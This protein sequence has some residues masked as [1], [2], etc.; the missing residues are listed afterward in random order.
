M[1][2][3]S[4]VFEQVLTTFE[5]VL[6]HLVH[7]FPHDPAAPPTPPERWGVDVARAQDMLLLHFSF[8]N[9]I[10]VDDPDGP[11]LMR[12]T[13]DEDAYVVVRFPPQSLIEK[14]FDEN[15]AAPAPPGPEPI[16]VPTTAR[17]AQP[18]RLAFRV[19][20]HV[21]RIPLTLEALLDWES[22]SPHLAPAALPRGAAP[23]PAPP[24]RPLAGHE[25]AIELPYR[26]LL[27]PDETAVWRHATKPVEHSGRVELWHT[28]L[29][30][31][32]DAPETGDAGSVRAVW[33]PDVRVVPT[34][35][36]PRDMTFPMDADDR[37]GIVHQSA[38]FALGS[39]PATDTAPITAEQ[40]MLSATGGW[41][42]SVGMWRGTS[43]ISLSEWRHR[44][45]EGRDH[46]V[47]IVRE[48]ILF[49]FGHRAAVVKISERKVEGLKADGSDPVAA[50]RRRFYII[51]RQLERTYASGDYD[52]GGREFPLPVVRFVT[53]VTPNIDT[54]THEPNTTGTFWVR[55]AGA[56]Y[57]FALDGDDH[58]GHTVPF[59]AACL[60]V[61]LQDMPTPLP[62]VPRGA[63]GVAIPQLVFD[64]T[65]DQSL[66]AAIYADPA[67]A[68]AR[69]ADVEGRR[70]AFVPGSGA[71]AG[72]QGELA[73]DT[74]VLTAQVGPVKHRPGGATGR[75]SWPGVVPALA[76][77]T[78][79]I[80][81]L[82]T[83]AQSPATTV[84]YHDHYLDHAFD[85]VANHLEVF[86]RTVG[87]KLPFDFPADRASG[88]VT[89]S[90]SVDGLSRLRGPLGDVDK[91]VSGTF[92]PTSFFG[93]A[94]L[95]GG[96]SLSDLIDAAGGPDPV[97]MPR[98]VTE[99]EGLRM[100]TRIDWTPKVTDHGV[101]AWLAPPAGKAS[102]ELHAELAAGPGAAPGATVSAT[103]RALRL[104][105]P[106][107][108]PWITVTFD[109]L[110]CEL[111]PGQKPQI[112][113]ALRTP[114]LE[115]GGPL[116]FVGEL[117]KILPADGLSAGPSIDLTATGLGVGY[118][119]AIPPLAVGVF[120]LQDLRL[121][122]SL[123]LPFTGAPAR[124]RFA[125]SSR[126]HPCVL[127]VS[128]FG[129]GAFL[130]IGAGTDGI[131]LI[132][133]A[134]EFG[135][136]FSID[137]VVASGGVTV[138]AG[139]YFRYE[140]TAGLTL[141]GYFRASGSVEVLGLVSVSVDFMLSICYEDSTGKVTGEASLT[142]KVDLKLI[143]KSVS[144]RCR[145]SFGGSA[146]DPTF[147]DLIGPGDWAE[148][149]NAFAA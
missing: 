147:A 8:I 70:I 93:D 31:S 142:V 50:L 26:L 136:S 133:G 16:V 113:V 79:R 63:G 104:G 95:L 87:G 119:L 40:L 42:R 39:R 12:E 140:I 89:P 3:R 66:A 35:H 148:Y 130:A 73:T 51:V 13:D 149:R 77:A 137:L 68:N 60:F 46:E 117:Q 29:R 38:N 30:P 23:V 94:K 143:S 126:E 115:F 18:S 146:G 7:L 67:R 33:S 37:H 49:P 102:L 83:L 2:E 85:A 138:M 56:F 128:L 103:L 15:P 45:T 84:A 132:E 27:S 91:L 36:P 131:E 59:H 71:L 28:R 54:P 100:V 11:I 41:L 78:V 125:F 24:L 141:C 120:S 65:P 4:N 82:T 105:I 108:D 111:L 9:L 106:G 112:R 129:G 5:G 53:H 96:V 64:P 21:N 75:R 44:A 122:G 145:R 101:I 52:A 32:K 134:L 123:H 127:T 124:L 61:D 62:H 135:G 110:R 107:K 43:L 88:L 114:P 25:T 10:P 47:K 81:A 116:S 121:G 34:D 86:A 80:P 92:D 48:G 76:R 58:D 14:V 98:I 109:E 6:S 74:L 22:W 1:P 72:G 99:R 19:H 57:P 69:D 118:A 97:Q 144:L 20:R 55:S 139:I 90:I 17:L